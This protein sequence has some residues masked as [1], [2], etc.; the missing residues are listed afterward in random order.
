MRVGV[1]QLASVAA[2]NALD[3]DFKVQFADRFTELPHVDDLM[4]VYHRVQLKD[5][6]QVVACKGYGCPCKYREAWL[7]LIQP[8]TS[9]YTPPAFIVSKANNLVLPRWVN[10]YQKIN[11]NTIS[12]KYPL[13]WVDN[14]LA[15]CTKGKI[16]EKIDMSNSLFQ[17]RMHPDD[18]KYMAVITPEGAFKWTVMPMGFKNSLSTH[19]RRMNS[20]LRNLIRKICHVYLDDI[21]IWSQ[22]LEEHKAN[23][24]TVMLALRKASLLCSPKKT[25][26]FCTE[27]DFLGHHISSRGI[28]PNAAK[29]QRIMD[30][31][32]PCSAKEVCSFLGLVRYIAAFLPKLAEHTRVLT[33]LTSKSCN[34]VFP[35]WMAEHELA[36]HAIKD[37]VLSADCLT[38]I[39]HVNPGTKKIFV[40]CDASNWRTGAVLSFGKTWEMAHLVAFDSQQLNSTQLNYPVHEKELLAIIH[41]LTKWRV[42]L[43]GS[44]ILIYTDHRTLEAF[45]RQRDLSCRQC[46]WQEFLTQY[47]YKITYIKGE[48]N[49]VADALSRL[50][51]DADLDHEL[52]PGI[53][54]VLLAAIFSISGD[55][56]LLSDIKKGYGKDPFCRKLFKNASSV[57]GFHVKDGLGYVGSRL[58]IPCFGD[59]CEQL[60][61]LAHSSMSHFGFKKLYGSLRESYYWPNMRRMLTSPLA[62]TVNTTRAGRTNRLAHFTPYWYLMLGLTVWCGD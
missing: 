25:H 58:V 18:I 28:E 10:N 54:N 16:W 17:T 12:D 45:D 19:Q 24:E 51:N 52:P 32:S 62:T 61:H 27:I 59:L 44:E 56:S 2:M 49:T 46:R 35:K 42:D 50:P 29:V 7:I 22:T 39:D 5:L 4:D 41:A 60:F 14:I 34:V 40:M 20:A 31:K 21:I 15:D 11:A 23:V 47:D 1:E 33:P 30:W 26:I 13:P 38:T 9:P 8:S 48:D 43:V 57:P 3:V 55:A 53:D 37:L 36:F 6:Y